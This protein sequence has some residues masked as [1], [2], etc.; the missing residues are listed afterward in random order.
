[1][2]PFTI[3]KKYKTKRQFNKNA[4]VGKNFKN[5][6]NVCV[7]TGF[8]NRIFVGDDCTVG[9]DLFCTSSGGIHIGNN[10]WIGGRSIIRSTKSVIIG[11]HCLISTDVVIQD[12]NSHPIDPVER[13]DQISRA[14]AGHNIDLW[15]ESDSGEIVIGNDVWIGLRSIILKS[16]CI[17]DGAIIAAGSVVTKNVA[18]KTIVG[19]NPAVVLK[20]IISPSL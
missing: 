9:A 13:R 11:S 2:N 17:G 14:G 1:V 5:G 16:V 20:S 12:N 7:N 19:G 10:T 6:H 4:V 15:K 18:P 3:Y 8:R